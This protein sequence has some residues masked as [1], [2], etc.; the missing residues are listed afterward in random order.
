MSSPD[1]AEF[2][3]IFIEVA[4]QLSPTGTLQL[5]RVVF[6]KRKVRHMI[7]NAYCSISY[8]CCGK[9]IHSGGR[10]GQVTPQ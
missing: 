6:Y 8:L 7:H 2:L 3:W 5:M 10:V 9:L 4:V 1:R